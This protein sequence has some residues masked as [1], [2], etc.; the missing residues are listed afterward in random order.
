MKVIKF[1]KIDQ[2]KATQ[3]FGFE[4][5]NLGEWGVVKTTL[6]SETLGKK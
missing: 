6:I 3:K 5:I 1:L 2:C 4:V